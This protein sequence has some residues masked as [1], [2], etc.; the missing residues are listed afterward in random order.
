MSASVDCLDE[1]I[2]DPLFI[3]AMREI[4]LLGALDDGDE[5]TMEKLARIL[6]RLVDD[7]ARLTIICDAPECHHAR[8]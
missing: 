3:V 1:E 6:V 7:H 2:L 5:S 8:P 4:V